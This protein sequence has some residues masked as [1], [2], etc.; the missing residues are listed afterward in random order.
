[1][2]C[3]WRLSNIALASGVTG[4]GLRSVSSR[5]SLILSLPNFLTRFRHSFSN[6]AAKKQP[7]ET[8]MPIWKLSGSKCFT[9]IRIS[10]VCFISWRVIMTIRPDDS[11]R[12]INWS[13][14]IIPVCGCS[15]RTSTSQPV[16][17]PVCAQKTGW[18][19]GLNSWFSNARLM[20]SGVTIWW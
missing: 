16:S 5:T 2:L 6:P 4:I 8:L 15:Q 14:G 13:G 18:I 7:A 10:A 3:W 9:G 12:G 20:A 11:A 17:T 19:H 1:M